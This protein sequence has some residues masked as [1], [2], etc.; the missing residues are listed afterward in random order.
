LAGHLKAE[1]FGLRAGPGGAACGGYVEGDTISTRRTED[2]T[3]AACWQAYAADRAVLLAAERVDNDRT[4]DLFSQALGE[5]GLEIAM[6]EEQLTE[7]R[8]VTPAPEV[9]AQD[10]ASQAVPGNGVGHGA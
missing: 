8:Q 3:C 9:C 1:T 4:W 7:A 5:A 10:A 6:L 2:V